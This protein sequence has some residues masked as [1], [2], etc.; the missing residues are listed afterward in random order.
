MSQRPT[1]RL[2]A[3]L[4]HPDDESLGIGG[5]LAYYA[6]QGVETYLV[7]A[8]RGE[9]GWTGPADQDPG[10]KALGELRTHELQGAA[11]TLGVCEVNFLD[12]IDG[13]LDQAEPVEAI[14]RIAGHVR[15]IRPQVVVTFDP[16]G[17]YGHPDHVAICQFTTAALVNAADPGYILPGGLPAYRVDKLYYYIVSPSQLDDWL[18]YFG[19]INMTV[20]GIT[21]TIAPVPAWSIHASV[22][23]S[24]YWQQVW[25]AIGHHRSQ[26]PD[27]DT[28]EIPPEAHQRLWGLQEFWRIYSTVNGGREQETDLF[29][30]IR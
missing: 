17:T 10:L 7:C 2:L 28:K 27:Y 22:D 25:Q 15:R 29:A 30:G 23:A 9:R 12:Y 6:D 19:E 8:T 20:D 4:A 5:T 26:I 18:R 24:A 1:L 3:V 21:R 11:R 16:T 13:D 14:A